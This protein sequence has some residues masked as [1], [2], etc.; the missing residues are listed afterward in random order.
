LPGILTCF[1][2]GSLHDHGELPVWSFAVCCENEAVRLYGA[3]WR[4]VAHACLAWVH[5]TCLRSHAQLART[6]RLLRASMRHA[7]LVL[8]L[9]V[10]ERIFG[11][12]LQA[13]GPQRGWCLPAWPKQAQIIA[14]GCNSVTKVASHQFVQ[15]V[16]ACQEAMTC[17]CL[18]NGT[19][20]YD[21]RKSR[22]PISRPC[23]VSLELAELPLTQASFL[24]TAMPS[25]GCAVQWNC[26][27][28]AI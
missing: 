3:L 25:R 12:C 7:L 27:C 2:L 11:T 28:P 19:A 17:M 10:L 23:K 6:W 15:E 20:C 18:L 8:S 13:F 5:C 16:C 14:R 1:C 9:C 26:S 24:P 21:T 22:T 4:G